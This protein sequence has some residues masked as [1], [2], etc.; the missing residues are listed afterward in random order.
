MKTTLSLFLLLLTGCALLNQPASDSSPA[1]YSESKDPDYNP[2]IERVEVVSLGEAFPKT[3]PKTITAM[4]SVPSQG[5]KEIAILMVKAEGSGE[6]Y[7]DL[8]Q[9]LKTKAAFMGATALI[10]LEAG[11]IP[12]EKSGFHMTIGTR[13]NSNFPQRS[14]VKYVKQVRA[15]AVRFG[16]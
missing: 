9:I 13:P 4:T 12:V 16:R 11:E 10:K 5:F 15:T 2:A 3:S 6:S 14:P 7:E 1:A 8:T